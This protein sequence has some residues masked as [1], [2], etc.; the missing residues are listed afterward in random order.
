MATIRW[1]PIFPKWDSYQALLWPLYGHLMVAFFDLSTWTWRLGRHAH[2]AA[3]SRTSKTIATP[4]VT[5]WKMYENVCSLKNF[6]FRIGDSCI[7]LLQRDIKTNGKTNNSDSSLQISAAPQRIDTSSLLAQPNHSL[8]VLVE[9][10]LPIGIVHCELSKVHSHERIKAR[11]FGF[12]D[13]QNISKNLGYFQGKPFWK[14]KT[15]VL[16]SHSEDFPRP[17][18]ARLTHGI[19]THWGSNR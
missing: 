13:G 6:P 17:W 14:R 16:P 3:L 8:H 9:A 10:Q 5:W 18:S 4:L 7:F 11:F 12:L 1:C 15:T 2:T 19:A